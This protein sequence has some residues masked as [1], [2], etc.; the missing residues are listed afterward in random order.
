MQAKFSGTCRD[1]GNKFPAGTD[2]D[3]QKGQGASCC[4]GSHQADRTSKTPI[5]F[6]GA[7]QMEWVKGKTT[8]EVVGYQGD[9][10]IYEQKEYNGYS[11]MC[12]ECRLVWERRHQATNC[13][14]RGHVA[15][16]EQSY[17]GILWD[18]RGFTPHG[19]VAGKYLPN[20]GTT[21]VRTAIRREKS[22][23]TPPVAPAPVDEIPKCDQCGQ[24]F[25]AA[26]PAQ[27]DS[28]FGK[29]RW[30]HYYCTYKGAMGVPQVEEP[31]PQADMTSEE[32]WES[33]ASVNQ[34]SITTTWN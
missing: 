24:V 17:G 28:L 18:G 4:N 14:S 22:T 10:L 1:C 25:T 29:Q 27:R 20:T 26:Y 3:W 21:Y 34:P 12:I 8:Q 5:V 2:I 15:S 23:D 11:W 13:E 33:M 31:A 32:M 7:Q 16:F 6:E 9:S 30:V 19:L